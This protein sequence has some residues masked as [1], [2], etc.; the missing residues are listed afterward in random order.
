MARHAAGD[1]VD[2]VLDVDAL[3]L[4]Q[5]REV[6]H[7]VL[8]LRDGE[9]VAGDEDDAARVGEHDR[10]VVRG[11]RATGAPS[12]PAALRPRSRDLPN[13]P[14]RTFAIER[15][16][17]RAISVVSSVPEAPTSIPLT[18]RTFECSTKPVAAAARPV[19]AFRSEITTGMSAPPIGRTNTTPNRAATTIA[20]ASSQQL[21]VAIAAAPRAIEPTKQDRVPDLLARVRDRPPAS[22]SC[23]LPNAISEPAN[24]IEPTSAEKTVATPRSTPTSP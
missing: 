18:I 3:L 22:S 24:E 6:A 2:R 21:T 5:L 14:K 8:R 17:A 11:R 23:S 9:P 10:D 16:I 15:F 7:V 1:R 4:E 13:A 12:A 19:N 20:A